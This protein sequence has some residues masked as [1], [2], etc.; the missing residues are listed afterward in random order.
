MIARYTSSI[1]TKAVRD[2]TDDDLVRLLNPLWVRQP[3]LA[4]RLRSR[5]EKILDY[6]KAHKQREGDNPASWKGNLKY[7]LAKLPPKRMR[8]QHLAALPYIAIPDFMTKLRKLGEEDIRA[9]ALEFTILTA[10]R[11]GETFGASWTEI[12][13]EARLWTIPGPRMKMG[14]EH[15]VPLSERALAIV[16]YQWE[17]RQNELV[18]PGYKE[19]RPLGTDAM[20]KMLARLNVD[21]TVHGFR[22]T[23][24]RW[25][26]DSTTFPREIAEYALAHQPAGEAERAYLRSAT[27]LNK[28]RVLMDEWAAYCELKP[29]SITRLHAKGQPILGSTG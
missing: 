15:I 11:T 2:I 21:V 14:E 6:A 8:V 26:Q 7:R 17:E 23:F 19:G 16:Q 20:L 12:D 24:R 28:R 25:V 29:G 13:V 4:H 10:A 22:S 1:T 3:D 9:R 27:A 5:I 18:F